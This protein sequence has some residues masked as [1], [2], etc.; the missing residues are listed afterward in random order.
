MD[1]RMPG[2]FSSIRWMR[3]RD[4]VE[5][6]ETAP[7][8]DRRDNNSVEYADLRGAVQIAEE[9][10]R[11]DELRGFT[12]SEVENGSCAADLRLSDRIAERAYFRWVEAG[13]PACRDMDYWLTAER[14]VLAEIEAAK[15]ARMQG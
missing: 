4:G 3:Q 14:E 12:A 1:V 2:I 10:I 5:S 6:T 13:S 7:R 8:R 11:D 15:R 9:E